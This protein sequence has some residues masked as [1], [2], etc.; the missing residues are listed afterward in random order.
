VVWHPIILMDGFKT[1]KPVLHLALQC[2]QMSLNSTQACIVVRAH[3]VPQREP[4]VSHRYVATVTY[5]PV[6]GL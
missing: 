2:A 1:T 6:L 4:A 5:V 3:L